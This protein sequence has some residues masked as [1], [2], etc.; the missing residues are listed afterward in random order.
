MKVLIIGGTRFIGK[1]IVRDCLAQGHEVTLF[2]RG[3][4]KSDFD[5][6]P[7]K[8]HLHKIIPIGAGLGGG[9]SDA[10]FALSLLNS[11]FSLGLSDSKLMGYAVGLGADCSF[12][13]KNKPMLAK[14]IG[15]KLEDIDITCEGKFII[16]V[17]PGIHISTK[18]AYSKISPRLPEVSVAEILTNKDFRQW[19]HYLK[20]DFEISLFESYPILSEIKQR[21]YDSGAIYAS[22]S[23]SGSCMYGI[24]TKEIEIHFPDNYTVWSGQLN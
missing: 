10:A 14:G 2:N 12:F 11:M 18:E 5:L 19:K 24:F 8:I 16:L 6:P 9:S 13:I 23:G 21:L 7:V 1:Y 15:E 3:Q 4:T 22:M 20:N 17:Y